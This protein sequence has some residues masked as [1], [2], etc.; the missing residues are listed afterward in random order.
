MKKPTKII[1]SIAATFV[2][3]ASIATV[4][5]LKTDNTNQP[6]T[7]LPIIST[8]LPTQPLET[9]SAFDWDAYLSSLDL[10]TEPESSTDNPALSTTIPSTSPNVIISYV[11]PDDYVPQTVPT[12]PQ[13]KPDA[14]TEPTTARV[15]MVDYKYSVDTENKSVTLLK[16]IGNDSTPTIPETVNG[17]NVTTIG[18]SCFK[19]SDI[20]GVYIAKTVTTISTAAFNNC[21]NL[22]N[23]YFLG[24]NYVEIGESVF[25]NCISLTN[26]FLS[27]NT[28]SIGAN[29]FANCTALKK[30]KIPEAVT[31]IGQNAFA[32]CSKDLTIVCKSGTLAETVALG[33]EFKIEIE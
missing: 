23:V 16:Y 11:Y 17:M 18:N 9:V 27:A 8:T 31:V 12:K 30:I 7:T 2:L 15:E 21:Q 26:V 5:I 4:S 10:S 22:K 14:E 32:G 19:S 6:T 29:A 3:I 24:T 13:N 25:E 33:Y 28:T 1:A 20:T